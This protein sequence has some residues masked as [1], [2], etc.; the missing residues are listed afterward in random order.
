MVYI[1]VKDEDPTQTYEQAGNNIIPVAWDSNPFDHMLSSSII[2]LIQ[3]D[4]VRHMYNYCCYCM[5][6][7][8]Y[9]PHEHVYVKVANTKACIIQR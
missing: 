3:K 6:V 5:H 4:I 8:S 9:I 2:Q 7:L 1:P